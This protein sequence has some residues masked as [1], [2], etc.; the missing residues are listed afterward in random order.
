[1]NALR[2]R[3]LGQIADHLDVFRASLEDIKVDEEA[4]RDNIPEGLRD[5]PVYYRAK[6]ACADLSR[7]IDNLDDAVTAIQEARLA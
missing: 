3:T 4:A 6:K 5:S 7:A 2:S 1:M